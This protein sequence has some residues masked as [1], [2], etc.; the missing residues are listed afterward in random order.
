MP[1]TEKARIKFSGHTLTGLREENQDAV[2][3]KYPTDSNELEYKGIVACIAD[4]VSCSHQAQQASQTATT[5][6]V[7]DYYSTPSGWSVKHSAGQI[8]N[9]INSWLYNQGKNQLTHN[10]MVT[11][12]SCVIIKSNTAHLFHIGDSRIYLYRDGKLTQ[13]TRDHQRVAFGKQRIL[14]RALGMDDHAEIDYQSQAL[15]KNDVL[16]LTTD[17]IHEFLSDTELHNLISN[18]GNQSTEQLSQSICQSALNAGSTDNTSCLVM[19][20]TDLPDT[21]LFEHQRTLISRKIPPALSKGQSIDHFEIIKTLHAGSRSHVYLAIDK[22]CQEKRVLKVPSMHYAE[23]SSALKLFAN[24]Y[25]VAS[26]LDN[27]RIMK[28]YPCAADSSFIYQVCEFIEGVTLRQWIY[29][30]P[31]PS[32]E[33]AR[34]ILEQIIRALRVF[35]RADMVHRDLKPEN[36]MITADDEV[37]IIDFGTVEV[38]GLNEGTNE[39]SD[40]F[41]LGSVNYTA[42]EYIN[43]GKATILSDLFSAGVIGYEMLCGHLPYKENSQQNIQWARHTKWHYRSIQDFRDDIPLWV[44]LAF[45]KATHANP[46]FRYQALGDFITDITTPNIQLLQGTNNKTLLRRNPVLFWKS[47]ALVACA[48]AVIEGL[49]LI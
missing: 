6:F 44:D 35:Q 37:K 40:A 33:S 47:L 8:L 42:P 45:E 3:A 32:M 48:I 23:D 34:R 46:H 13:L 31:M 30:H 49:L 28:M 11:T 21:N 43:T 36:I 29:D 5:Q 27:H 15:Q 9:G 38:T 18:S 14:T 26:Q 4:G 17:G 41:P 22:R 10:G 24:E 2:I 12:F 1:D 19:S 20:V 25:W 39:M 16:L 7:S